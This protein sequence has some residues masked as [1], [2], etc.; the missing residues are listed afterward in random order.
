ME[1]NNYDSKVVVTALRKLQKIHGNES[2]KFSSH[3]APGGRPD[4]LER[5]M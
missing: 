3:P 1:I 4:A 2:S 5:M